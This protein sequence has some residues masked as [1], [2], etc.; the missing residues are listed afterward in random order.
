MLQGKFVFCRWLD[1]IG[2]LTR[3]VVI[4]KYSVQIVDI[5]CDNSHVPCVLKDHYFVR[6]N[7]GLRV[8]TTENRRL[9]LM[10]F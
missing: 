9:Q 2:C 6:K 3:S 1:K 8:T 4:S 10:L 7:N 5:K